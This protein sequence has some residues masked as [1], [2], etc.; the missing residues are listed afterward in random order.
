MSLKRV[1]GAAGSAV[2]S[3]EVFSVGC[4][5]CC[6]WGS[7]GGGVEGEYWTGD[8]FFRNAWR[9]GS[10]SRRGSEEDFFSSVVA[11][12]NQPI[13]AVC[14]GRVVVELGLW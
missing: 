4:V 11:P 5:G 9:L 7:V 12:Q 10:R 1:G 3:E 13:F 6:A 2:G 14:G 8:S